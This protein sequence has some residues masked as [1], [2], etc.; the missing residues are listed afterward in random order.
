MKLVVGLGNPGN[1]YKDTYHNIGFHA[2]DRLAS[3]FQTPD[4]TL[5]KKSN[6][7]LSSAVLFGQNT[8]L[9]KPN[10]YMN[11]SGDA[12]SK[13]ARY[14]KTEP[15]DILVFYDDIDMAKGVV[16]ARM[17]GSAGTHNGMRDIVS[18]LGT[19]EF[20]RVRIGIGGKPD[21]MQLADY[22]LSKIPAGFKDIMDKACAAAADFAEEW[23]RG[24][25]WQ[26]QTVSVV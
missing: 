26:T 5:D 12:V 22:V 19:G 7:Y 10:T 25:P 6:A 3:R 15:C 21:Y 8:L 2:L 13:L 17:G 16:R 4:F 14:Y 11:L 9:C 1:D 20:P 18:K 24:E 23:L